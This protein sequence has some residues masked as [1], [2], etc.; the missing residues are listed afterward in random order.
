[1]NQVQA[2][3]MNFFGPI[4]AVCFWP[5]ASI[6]FIS[7]FWPTLLF[8]LQ[9]HHIRLWLPLMFVLMCLLLFF[10][11]HH[12]S[13][14]WFHYEMRKIFYS[15]CMRIRTTCLVCLRVTYLRKIKILTWRRE[16]SKAVSTFLCCVELQTTVFAWSCSHLLVRFCIHRC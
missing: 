13:C 16:F 11:L 3:T 8:H 15:N 9:E 5:L 12:F 14:G 6:V 2:E 1:M 4:R 7:I 10:C